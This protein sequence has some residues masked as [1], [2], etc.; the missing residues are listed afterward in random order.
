[1][2]PTEARRLPLSGIRVLD[3]SSVIMGPYATQI[4]AEYGA[5]V[6]KVEPP[7]GDIMR[8]MGPLRDPGLGPVFLNLNR[9]KRSLCLDLKTAEAREALARLLDRCDVF[10]SNIRPRAL[11]RLGLDW[12]TL[13]AAHPELI[14]VSLTG[15]GAEGPHA[16]KPAYDDLIQAMSGLPALAARASG[17]RPQ[18]LPMNIA[19]RTVGLFAAQA[20]L[21]AVLQR[22]AHG[23]GQCIELPM[24]ETLAGFML[25]DH[26]AGRSF[27][28]AMGEA[29]NARLLSRYR[30][31][32]ATADGWISALIY[33]SAHWRAFLEEVG[34]GERWNSDP[35]FHTMTSRTQNI[36]SL[37]AFV[38]EQLAL[39]GTADWLE[40]LTARD[41]P[42]AAL[43]D[44]D[45]LLED[46][47]LLASGVL[48]PYEDQQGQ[49]YLGLEPSVR[50]P[51][52]Q[53]QAGTAAP[54]LG[55]HS[56]DILRELGYGEADI[57]RL[58]A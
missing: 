25:G 15:F 11:T 18:Y 37:Y 55:E 20:V 4:L 12:D 22:Q 48:R 5:D 46:P 13:S 54:R 58:V 2:K 45:D 43:A 14:H 1:M 42:V 30:R 7:E 29:G 6:I 3:L 17:G 32:Y 27:Q 41:I 53:P 16:N 34:E 56:R 36:D 8:G 24:Y 47:Q 28:P 57:G 38:E 19:D 21:A 31:P 10:I 35:R 40:A 44:L 26:L 52:A 49:R 9:G 23:G 39:R 33:T 50:W 51:Q